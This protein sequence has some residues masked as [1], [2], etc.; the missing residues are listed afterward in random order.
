M[1]FRIITFFRVPGFQGSKCLSMTVDLV[2]LGTLIYIFRV[3]IYILGFQTFFYKML[4]TLIF[5]IGS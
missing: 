4:K 1:K 2:F 3:P 5:F